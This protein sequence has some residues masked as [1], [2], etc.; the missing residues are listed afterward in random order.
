ML[1]IQKECSDSNKTFFIVLTIFFLILSPFS[2]SHAVSELNQHNDPIAPVILSVTGLLFFALLGRFAARKCRQPSVLGELIVGIFIGNILYYFGVD[3]I[4]VLREGSAIFEIVDLTLQG[5][6][7]EEAAHNTL[8]KNA[9]DLI[10]IMRSTQGATMLQIAQ[11]VDVFSRY[12]VIFLLFLVGLESSI[13]EMKSVGGDSLRV[14]IIGVALP[15]ILGFMTI[16]WLMP[17]QSSNTHLFVASTLAATSIGI[18]AS[19]LHDLGQLHV[20]EAHIILG[21]AVIDDILG[22]VILAIVTGII[23]SGGVNTSDILSIVG[24]SALFL[25][26]AILLSPYFLKIAIK[27]VHHMN[28]GE[29]KLFITFLFVM[30][31]AWFASLVGLA[32]I[33]GAF[34]AGLI[35]HDAY[36]KH[37]GDHH[38]H[39]VSIK[40]MVAPLEAILVPIFFVLMGIQV[41]LEAFLNPHIL[42][43]AT[44]LLLAAAVGKI[45][46]GFGA[47]KDTN[48]WTIGIGMMPRGEVGLVF[49]SIGKSLGVISTEL[50]SAIVL[51]IIV[52]T[53][54]TP[55]LLK[56]F[57]YRTKKI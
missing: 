2:A 51:M 30:A 13:N 19:V 32:A 8:D 45:V 16:Y 5:E 33:V 49:A 18:T 47:G 7:W 10:T 54:A 35:L 11:T 23:V 42:Y 31:L 20:K 9:D 37:W 17:E 53:L 3:I 24:L 57:I 36:F 43:V 1:A 12:G 22:L 34:T 27:L 25:T 21:A 44:G 28:L 48:R 14:A 15:L 39:R 40:D 6:T 52:T 4:K 46:S 41:K 55:P 26:S 56:Y 38:Q 29:A 50:F